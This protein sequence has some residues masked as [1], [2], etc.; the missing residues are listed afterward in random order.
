MT[1]IKSEERAVTPTRW[2]VDHDETSVAFAVKTMCGLI[3]VRGRRS[4]STASRRR[5]A[6][7]VTHWSVRTGGGKG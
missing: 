4:S 7:S 2:S 5:P 1:T 6:R 3:P